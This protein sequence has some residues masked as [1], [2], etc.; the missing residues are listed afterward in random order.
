LRLCI[1]INIWVGIWSERA[2]E[3]VR[4]II[5]L[6]KSG[7]EYLDPYLTISGRDQL[8]MHDTGDAGVLATAIPI[9]VANWFED[10]VTITPQWVSQ[11]YHS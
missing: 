3:L 10:N 7:P 9:D 4:T 5:D 1:D 11:R 6:M 8:C 2:H